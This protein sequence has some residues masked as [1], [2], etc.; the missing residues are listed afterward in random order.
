MLSYP[1]HFG[2]MDIYS[3]LHELPS[4]SVIYQ[5]P[6]IKKGFTY[7]SDDTLIL[8]TD[9]L[10]FSKIFSYENLLDIDK[11]HCNDIYAVS[12]TY[13]IEAA[14]RVLVKEVKDVFKVCILSSKKFEI[15]ISVVIKFK[16]CNILT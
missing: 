13:G 3:L 9:G 14:A 6:G 1:V 2:C 8:K 7:I 4:K 15:I 11:L 12:K 10:N 5:V 16:Q